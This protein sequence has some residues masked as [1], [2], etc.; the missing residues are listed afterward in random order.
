MFATYIA[1]LDVLLANARRIRN[2]CILVLICVVIAAFILSHYVTISISDPIRRL[3]RVM[4]KTADGRWTARYENSGNDEITILGDQFNEMAEK[5]NQLIEQVY[6]SEIR[7]Q[8]A[9]IS[10][11]MHSWTPC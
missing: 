11:K 3:V 7:R 1:D 10:W 5:T 6:L 8:R 2:L 9:Q 4:G